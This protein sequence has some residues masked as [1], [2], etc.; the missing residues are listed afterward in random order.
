MWRDGQ[1]AAVLDWEDAAMGDPLSDVACARVELCCARDADCADRFT[2]VY[3]DQSGMDLDR[4]PW[5]DLFVS[6]AALQS[7]DSWK[8]S[9]EALAA[10]RTA[11][12]AWQATALRTLGLD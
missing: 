4:L 8:L 12:S 3:A 1:L 5:W 6:S 7:M 10:R 11:T 9:P 2:R